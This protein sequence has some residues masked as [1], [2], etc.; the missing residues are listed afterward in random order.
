MWNAYRDWPDGVDGLYWLESRPGLPAVAYHAGAG[1]TPYVSAAFSVDGPIQ[2]LHGDAFVARAQE[3]F[4]Q[5]MAGWGSSAQLVT[6]IQI[7][8]R[9]IPADSAL[10]EM[11]LQDQLDPDAP[12]DLQTDYTTLLGQLSSSSFVQRH[13]VVVLWDRGR[14]VP[15]P[16]PPAGPRPGR[17]AVAGERRDRDP[18]TAG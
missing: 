11:W 16:R 18:R 4:G 1:E 15:G 13:Y 10:H 8:T 17:L 2:G 9:V 3:A 6:G 7:L 5:L 12:Q 14:P